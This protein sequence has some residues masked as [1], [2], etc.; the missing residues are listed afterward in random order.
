MD[1]QTKESKKV[2]FEKVLRNFPATLESNFQDAVKSQAIAKSIENG[3]MFDINLNAIKYELMISLKDDFDNVLELFNRSY[4]EVNEES[5][6][7]FLLHYTELLKINARLNFPIGLK[8]FEDIVELDVSDRKLEYN[9][10]TKDNEELIR[11]IG[12]EIL[13]DDKK[14]EPLLHEKI[15]PVL[16]K[17]LAKYDIPISFA[18]DMDNDFY[19]VMFTH[20][21]DEQI[22][23]K[24]SYLNKCDYP[25]A[26]ING[27][28]E[29]AKQIVID[30]IPYANI[31]TFTNDIQKHKY[32]TDIKE[33]KENFELDIDRLPKGLLKIQGLLSNETSEIKAQKNK[34]NTTFS[35]VEQ[36]V[37]EHFDNLKSFITPKIVSPKDVSELQ[38]L[39]L[40]MIDEFGIYTNKQAN[41]YFY[42]T[43][44]FI[45]KVI[46]NK[47]YVF[48]KEN[49]QS[50]KFMIDYDL[51][52]IPLNKFFEI[53]KEKEMYDNLEID[54]EKMNISTF[55]ED[56]NDI[57][58]GN[59]TLAKKHA[60]KRELPTL[61]D[62]EL[63]DLAYNN[64]ELFYCE[65][66]K[67]SETSYLKDLAIELL[68]DRNVKTLEDAYKVLYDENGLYDKIIDDGIYSL[69]NGDE[70]GEYDD[71]FNL[72]IL[73]DKKEVA[74]LLVKGAK[75]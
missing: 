5:V 24:I 46:E 7:M 15:L 72:A 73:V 6:E 35:N 36:I 22:N 48:G 61:N 2:I 9:S 33:F 14:I 31:P 43:E 1:N 29:I 75:K 44:Y 60:L 20:R 3:A 30:G 4:D 65:I 19:N 54:V 66:D 26:R 57:V 70:R 74:K 47:L 63:R 23:H 62:E 17:K 64:E 21:E 18:M 58:N 27:N 8:D 37:D 56:A 51:D 25:N 38:T 34:I 49:Q 55:F 50:D 45:N 32:L 71:L 12:N 39:A 69:E 11:S 13:K 10:L 42:E 67:P 16:E 40:N 28:E 53:H 68:E 59:V 52:Y 41:R